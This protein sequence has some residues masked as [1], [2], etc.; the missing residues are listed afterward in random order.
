[1]AISQKTK[2]IIAGYRGQLQQ[3]LDANLADIQAHKDAIE[4]IKE[5]NIAL[6]AEFDAL[7]MDIAEPTPVE[8]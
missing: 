7:K 8:I 2:Q 5:R 1:M 3:R 6:K 4:Q